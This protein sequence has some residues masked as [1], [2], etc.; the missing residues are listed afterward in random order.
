[1]KI[2]SIIFVVSFLYSTT[3]ALAEYNP[4]TGEDDLI[5]IGEAQEVQLGK[6][7]AEGVEKKFG[8]VQDAG[9]QK[10]VNEVGQRIANVCDRQELTY[11]FIALKGEDL[12][13]EERYNAFTL[14]GGY[15]YIFKEMVEDM[16][17]DDELAAILAHEVGHIVARHSIK[18]LQSSI[19]MASLNLLGAV[20]TRDARTQTEA[21]I[22][23]AQL[24]MS[25]SREAEFE[26]DKLSVKYLKKANFDPKA[27]IAV[28]DRMLDK[29]LHG[30]I[31]RY[32][33]FR[34][35]PYTSERKAMINKEIG[36]RF[37]FDDY[38]NSPTE[39]SETSR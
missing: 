39:A 15:V 7:L 8:L 14:P 9:T 10:R 38:I 26:A 11:S 30:K 5:F 27:A 35:H 32:R 31:E 36:G 21:S 12:E 28:I 33:Y 23:I 4:A 25:Y 2:L 20:T 34:T 18:K 13:E 1:M 17:S 29:N 19:G 22:A 6:S 37:A 24:M 3:T 16:K